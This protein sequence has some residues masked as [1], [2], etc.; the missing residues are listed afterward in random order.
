MTPKEIAE[1]VDALENLWLQNR[2]ARDYLKKHCGMDD[3]DKF[4]QE[5]V[6]HMPLDSLGR[7]QFAAVKQKVGQGL[8]D[9]TVLEIFSA[10]RAQQS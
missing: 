1:F 6:N 10:I 5:Q 3:P 9:S 2:A 7:M 4:L 8:T